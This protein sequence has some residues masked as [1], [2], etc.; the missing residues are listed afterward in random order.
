MTKRHVGKCSPETDYTGCKAYRAIPLGKDVSRY[1]A[2]DEGVFHGRD[3]GLIKR[4]QGSWVGQRPFPNVWFMWAWYNRP[5]DSHLKFWNGW[6]ID[7]PSSLYIL[8]EGPGQKA[9][10]MWIQQTKF[11]VSC[12][13]RLFLSFGEYTFFNLTFVGV[14]NIK[15][16]GRRR[17]HHM[18][19]LL[20]LDSL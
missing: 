1:T 17:F 3:K 7:I 8:K 19:D 20:A 11:V 4:W 2:G 16:H 9:T 18:K 13:K 12:H 14:P 15:L 6:K 10:Q 5:W